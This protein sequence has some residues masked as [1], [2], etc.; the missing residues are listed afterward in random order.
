MSSKYL[1][2][3]NRVHRFG[4]SKTLIAPQL[5]H[6]QPSPVQLR[7]SYWTSRIPFV[8]ESLVLTHSVLE[9]IHTYTGLP[10]AASIP[11]T[12]LLVSAVVMFP[13]SYYNR[14][15]ALARIKL[16]PKIEEAKHA[17]QKKVTQKFIARNAREKERIAEIETLRYG[18]GLMKDKRLQAWRG[19]IIFAYFPVWYAFMETL[20]NMTGSQEGFLGLVVTPLM[21]GG[22][23]MPAAIEGTIIAMEPSFLVEGMLWFPNLL[24]PD[25]YH[26][27]SIILCATHYASLRKSIGVSVMSYSPKAGMDYARKHNERIYLA[28][29]VLTIAVLPAR[30]QFTSAILLFWISCLL[31]KIIS[32]EISAKLIPLDFDPV[33]TITKLPQTPKKQQ[34]RGPTMKDVRGQGKKKKTSK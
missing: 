31:C 32:R 22:K 2:F 10:W 17:F 28:Q 8:D 15:L 11:L 29:K 23:P 34:F 14:R 25:P 26:V 12:A 27:L 5:R 19:K 7:R 4:L 16:D 3:P 13:S 33:T 6:P 24:L 1:K 30:L 9:G 18:R 20:R 21:G